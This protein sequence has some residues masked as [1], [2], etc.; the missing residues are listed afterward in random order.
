MLPQKKF[1]F[2]FLFFE[3]SCTIRRP[4]F[5]LR[6]PL[7]GTGWANGWTEV[8]TTLKEEVSVKDVSPL[9]SSSGP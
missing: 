6:G 5:Y 8:V 1:E 7:V 9:Y 4:L 2:F 3:N